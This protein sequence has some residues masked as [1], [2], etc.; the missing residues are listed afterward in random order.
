[1]AQQSLPDILR[2]GNG[3][4]DKNGDDYRSWKSVQSRDDQ[5]RLEDGVARLSHGESIEVFF[6]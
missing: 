5:K 1:M 3:E 4:K 6:T 2:G